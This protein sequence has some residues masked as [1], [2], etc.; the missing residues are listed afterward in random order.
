MTALGGVMIPSL[1]PVLVVARLSSVAAAHFYIA[2][3]LSGILLTV[4]SAVSGNLLADLSYDDE[5]LASTVRRA[6]R[7]IAA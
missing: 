3:L 6:T 7:L 4:S 2:W 5:P 1:M